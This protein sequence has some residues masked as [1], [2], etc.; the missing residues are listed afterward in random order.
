MWLAMG[1]LVLAMMS[2]HSGASLAKS[3]FPEL[4]APGVSAYRL[5]FGAIFLLVAFRPWRTPLATLPWKAL[6]GYGLAM[7]A[8]NASF[9]LALARIPLGV[10]VA[11]EFTGPLLLALL[12]SRRA[13]DFAWVALAITGVAVLLPWSDEPAALDK[14]GVAYALCAAACW[15]LYIVFG[16]RSGSAY[17]LQ[18]V[19]I[20]SCIAAL[21][22]VPWGVSQAGSA[23]LSPGLLPSGMA[24][25]FLAVS[26]PFTLEMFAMTRM[27]TSTFGMM[28]SLE[29]A[30]GALC[31]IVF[32]H[33]QLTGL[34]WFAI[35]AVM[36]ATA[37]AAQTVQTAR[38]S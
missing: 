32:L 19:A 29:P 38:G 6:L 9:Y 27:P 8:M 4:G 23:L 35:G 34:Q 16:K 36:V 5:G 22:V 20:G 15:A 33:E 18:S 10:A 30:V 31:G 26:L 17:G 3:L 7:G 14:L 1:V 11:L 12:G 24:V 21:F 13:I 28:M 2:I 37:G 25:A